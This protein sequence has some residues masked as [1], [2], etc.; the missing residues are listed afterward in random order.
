M[1]FLR[2]LHISVIEKEI[3]SVAKVIIE[4]TRANNQLLKLTDDI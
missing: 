3:I 4:C 1:M 2:Q